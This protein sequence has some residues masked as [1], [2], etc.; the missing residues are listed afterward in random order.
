V[1]ITALYDADGRVAGFGKVTRDE[2][3]RR[4]GERQAH[5]LG[6]LADREAIGR[7]L[8]DTVVHGIFEAGLDLQAAL[9]LLSDPAAID[10]VE[11]AVE[12]LDDTVREIRHVVLRLDADDT[13]C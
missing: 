13:S 7:G 8:S 2:T 4:D 11:H 10:R 5:Q 6:R 12:V 3:D 1:V 9:R